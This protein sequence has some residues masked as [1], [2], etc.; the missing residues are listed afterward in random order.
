MLVKIKKNARNVKLY[1]MYLV[2][3]HMDLTK[4]QLCNVLC[5]FIRRPYRRFNSM[6]HSTL[7]LT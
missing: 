4:V 3:Q 7:G 5:L 1:L 2:L 6:K